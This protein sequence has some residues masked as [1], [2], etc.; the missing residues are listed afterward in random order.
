MFCQFWKETTKPQW[1]Y[2][3]V[4]Q[5]CQKYISR[6]VTDESSLLF[7]KRTMCSTLKE[8]YPYSSG[9]MIEKSQGSQRSKSGKL[10]KNT[11]WI[12]WKLCA[13][14]VFDQNLFLWPEEW[15]HSGPNWETLKCCHFS[16]WQWLKRSGNTLPQKNLCRHTNP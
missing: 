16:G 5:A 9:V 6:R 14:K 15:C 8:K 7:I 4:S 2:I 3:N 1:W 12:I 11:H 13:V 10:S